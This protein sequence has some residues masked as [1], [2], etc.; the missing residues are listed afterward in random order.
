MARSTSLLK[1]LLAVDWVEMP[2]CLTTHECRNV[3]EELSDG[4]GNTEPGR[5]PSPDGQSGCGGPSK[6]RSA[7]QIGQ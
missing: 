4:G 7:Y 6:H 3:L 1:S 2:A 5:C